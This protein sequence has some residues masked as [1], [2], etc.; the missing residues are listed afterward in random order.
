MKEKEKSKIH[1]TGLSGDLELLQGS[2]KQGHV[3]LKGTRGRREFVIV[4]LAALSSNVVDLDGGE[5]ETRRGR[6]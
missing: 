4:R 1:Q 3:C 6:S 2:R 5:R